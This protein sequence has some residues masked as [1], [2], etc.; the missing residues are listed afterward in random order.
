MADTTGTILNQTRFTDISTGVDLKLAVYQESTIIYFSMN[1]SA[2][3]LG[4]FGVLSFNHIKKIKITGSYPLVGV[5]HTFYLETIINGDTL[6]CMS[7]DY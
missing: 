1:N 2:I 5:T 7:T 6:I 3:H 4:F